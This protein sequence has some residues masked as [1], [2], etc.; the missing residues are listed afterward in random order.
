MYSRSKGMTGRDYHLTPPP[1]YDGSRFGT[2]SDGRDDAF[3][4]YREERHLHH[5]E[6]SE[7]DRIS[8][9]SKEDHT[10]HSPS[11]QYETAEDLCDDL[12]KE[13]CAECLEKDVCAEA[14]EHPPS[15]SKPFSVSNFLKKLGNEEIL[16]IAL[17]I[18][19]AGSQSNAQGDTL[20]IL[21]LL[22]CIT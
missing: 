22:L 19:L 21:A 16:L 17:I 5:R 13:E 10:E 4:P 3:P 8:V 14:R 9:K 20:L 15:E 1:G 7:H 6:E 18:L 12:T 11:V 2:R